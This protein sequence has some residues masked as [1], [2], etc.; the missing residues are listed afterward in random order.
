MS[1]GP[2]SVLLVE[3]NP[4]DE[5]L[6][7]RGLKRANLANQVDVARDGQ[8]AIDYLFGTEEQAPMSVPVVV[9]LDLKLPRVAGLDVLRRIRT[10]KRTRRIPVVILSSSTEDSDLIAGY[11]LG[12]NSYVCKP[13]EFESFATAIAQLG[14]YWLM[15]NQPAPPAEDSASAEQAA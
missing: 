8:E 9:L 12:A 1:E 14:V 13:I 4:D 11:D 6:T 7:I 2:P 15:I 10:E 5:E 3:D